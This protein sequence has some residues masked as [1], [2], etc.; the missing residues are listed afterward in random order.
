MATR[1][2]IDDIVNSYPMGEVEEYFDNLNNVIQVNS[3]NHTYRMSTH[4]SHTLPAP[5]KG[6][7]QTQFLLTDSTMDIVDISQGY[8]RLKVAM[9]LE[10][11]ISRAINDRNL[12]TAAA[13]YETYYRNM[14]YFFVGF[15][16]GSQLI[17]EYKVISYGQTS[18]CFQSNAVAEQTIVYNC[19]AEGERKARP[20]MYSNHEDVMEMNDCVCGV[21]VQ[22]PIITGATTIMSPIEFEVL[23]QV[24]DLLPFSGMSMYPVS[25]CKDLQLAIR[26][27]IQKNMVFCPI[28]VQAVFKHKPFTTEVDL[29]KQY[30]A[31]FADGTGT[32]QGPSQIST[33]A[34]NT[35]ALVN[36]QN[37]RTDFRFT[38]CGDYSEAIVGVTTE[39]KLAKDQ[40]TEDTE[41]LDFYGNH[42]YYTIVPTQLEIKEAQSYVFGFN[43]NE[44]SLENLK[45]LMI[46]RS[47]FF[48][49][50]QWIDHGSMPQLPEATGY[51]GDTN[52]SLFECDQL[53]FTFPNTPN[54][55]TVTRN[56]HFESYNVR[57]GSNINI[58]DLQMSTCCHSNT[59]MN[60]SALSLDTI[61][62]APKTTINSYNQNIEHR[63]DKWYG[64]KSV[65]DSDFM[66]VCDLERNGSGVFADGI[67][68]MNIPIRVEA[69][70]GQG[71]KNPHF[72]EYNGN[73][74]EGQEF[75]LRKYSPNYFTVSDACWVLGPNG[76]AFIKDASKKELTDLFEAKKKAEI[77]QYKQAIMQKLAA[78]SRQ[79]V[80]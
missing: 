18:D 25:I 45:R 66:M 80:V 65:D 33:W 27:D 50:A 52:K 16:S 43:L 10:F 44:G 48:I 37:M 47:G 39:Q 19:K 57:I 69:I 62:K 20:G 59:E 78:A 42:V 56:P 71:T 2:R 30:Q 22:Q 60:L 23:I 34:L 63:C 46:E 11:R 12:T 24:D 40:I 61:F 17:K 1:Q 29:H 55:M 73:A 9:N 3:G 7:Q 21:Y 14:C 53:I 51:R 75:S 35:T 6:S 41:D 68:G 79:N 36:T 70:Y 49:P 72:Y 31:Q 76:P 64:C 67:S 32:K 74:Y 4:V 54:Q 8:L 26:F 5:F 13:L 15:K 58:P 28:P 77:A 38:Q